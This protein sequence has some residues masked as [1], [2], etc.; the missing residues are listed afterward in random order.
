MPRPRKCRW[1]EALPSVRYFKPQGVP[2]RFLN[3][4]A[5][6]VEGLEALRLADVEGLDQETAAAQMKVSRPTFT[7]VLAEARQAV[8]KA[9]V[10]GWA[11]RV[12]GGNFV[13]AGEAEGGR[14]RAG[15]LGRGCCR[16]GCVNE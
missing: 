3:E 14:P 6:A 4:I 5:L 15:G 9:L 1:I 7:R 12:E 11:I 13:L 16:R 10:A 2:L 8:A